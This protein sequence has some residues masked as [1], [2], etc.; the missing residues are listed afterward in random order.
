MKNT[1][2]TTTRRTALHQML[3]A[4]VG[5]GLFG[6]PAFETSAQTT[7][8]RSKK[9]PL[10]PFYL[11][12][13][14]PLEMGTKGINMRT[15]I[16]SSQTNR[17]YSCV[18]FVVAPKQ[19]GPPP[20]I[21]KDLDEI[22]FVLQGTVSIMVGETVYQVQAGGWHLRPHGIVHTF[23]NATNEPARYIDMYFN[24]NF[25]DFLEELNNKLLPDME[26]NHL[27]PADPGIAK[28]WADLDK[29]FGITT[30][31]DKR[32]PIIDKYGLKA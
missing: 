30:F 19:M 17:Q 26:K 20:H 2:K 29:R 23:W 14:A 25:E 13:A 1:T 9:D 28:R 21:H 31:F 22:M 16:R 27:T 3:L 8:K 32:Q 24:Q 15:W 7:T 5:T 11:P 10:Q 12:P 4:S 18:E 6:M